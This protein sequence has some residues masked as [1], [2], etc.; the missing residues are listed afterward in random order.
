MPSMAKDN[1]TICLFNY[2]SLTRNLEPFRGRI[3]FLSPFLFIYLSWMAKVGVVWTLE[4]WALCL[5][6]FRIYPLRCSLPYSILLTLCLGSTLCRLYP[7]VILRWISNLSKRLLFPLN[8]SLWDT[9]LC[10]VIIRNLG[11]NLVF[12]Q[13]YLN[14]WTHLS[15][16]FLPH[17][18]SCSSCIQSNC[19]ELR[20]LNCEDTPN[21]QSLPNLSFKP[22]KTVA[23]LVF[24]SKHVLEF[25]NL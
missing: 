20:H 11:Y 12:S 7:W 6:W 4:K 23:W 15:I 2:L 24:Q 22:A 1:V 14:R 8:P 9:R 5:S 17:L 25:I 16:C 3:W 19:L 13:H 18:V 10:I 21:S